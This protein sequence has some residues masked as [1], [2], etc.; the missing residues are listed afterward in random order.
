MFSGGIEKDPA[1]ICPRLVHVTRIYKADQI[2]Y[3]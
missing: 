3:S 1:H 2:T